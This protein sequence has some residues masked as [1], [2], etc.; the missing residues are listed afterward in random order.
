M[1]NA[2]PV[3]DLLII[4]GGPAGITAAVQAVR[5]DLSVAV[6]E[7][8]RL[9][10]LLLNANLVE[11]YPMESPSKTGRDLAEVFKK[12]LDDFKIETIKDEIVKLVRT[13]NGEFELT[14]KI[15]SYTSRSVIIATGTVPKL[16]DIPGSDECCKKRTYYEL[17]DMHPL[18][19]GKSFVI[20]G[21]GDAAFDY[22][23]QLSRYEGRSTILVRGSRTSCLPLLYRRAEGAGE[24][25]S[26]I[27]NAE[28]KS[29]DYN[30]DEE[31]IIVSVSIGGTIKKI[32][33]DY[34]I[35]AV[36]RKQ[37][38]KLLRDFSA[39]TETEIIKELNGKTNIPGLYLAGDII[40]GS[41]RQVGIA[42]GDGIRAAMM[43]FE[44]IERDDSK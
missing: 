27:F 4:G 8:D 11:N 2:I 17:R 10:G 43:A 34:M 23:L 18:P 33:A 31:K 41:Y 15:G 38:D 7:R 24:T 36:G 20:I 5:S 39:E 3:H 16:I 42:V 25:I 9:G 40:H 19:E 14:G 1:V 28:V 44:F 22:A 35:T 32:H 21:G 30:K 29:M 12:R 26:V 6:I 37:N 13:G